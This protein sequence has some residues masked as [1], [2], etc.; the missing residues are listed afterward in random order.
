MCLW[1]SSVKPFRCLHAAPLARAAAVVRLWCDVLDSGHLEAGGL[2]RADSSLAARAGPL[3]ED[4]DLLKAVLD[5]L[6]GG[7]VSGHLGGER[8]RLARALEAGTAGGLPRDHVALAI[9]QRHDR[10]VERRLDVGLADRDVLANPTATTRWP[11]GR[12]AHSLPG[13]PARP[14][15]IVA[16]PP[17]TVLRGTSGPAF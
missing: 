10:V 4:L 2:E 17:S 11:L 15:E 1:P 8:R 14:S 5:A 12:W 7:S 6:A 3:D 13:P 9:G 16:R